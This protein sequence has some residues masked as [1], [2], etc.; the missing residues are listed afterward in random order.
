MPPEEVMLARGWEE[1]AS[2]RQP[3]WR[4]AKALGQEEPSEMPVWLEPRFRGKS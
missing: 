2:S 3:G 1:M 4:L